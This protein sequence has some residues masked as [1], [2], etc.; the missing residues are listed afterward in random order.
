MRRFFN[1]AGPCLPERHYLVPPES[2]LSEALDLI[3]RQ[4]FFVIHAPRQTGKTTLLHTLAKKLNAEGRYTALVT[5][6]EFLQRV[7]DVGAGLVELVQMIHNAG[8]YSSLAAEE[9]PPE[10]G[11]ISDHPLQALSTY[12][13]RWAEACPKPIVLLIDEIDSLTDDLLISVLRQLRS[14]YT[15]RQVAP[16]PSSVALVGLRDVRDYKAGL[17]DEQE[18]LGTASPFNV[19]ARSLTL[20]NFSAGEIRQ[21]LGQHTEDTGQRFEAQV[22]Q[23]IFEQT[24]G[25]PWLVNALAAECVDTLVKDR[26]QP[27]TSAHVMEAREILIRRRDTHLDSLADK[28]RE[29]RVRRIIEPILAGQVLPPEAMDDDLMYARDLGLVTIS[30]SVRIANPIYQEVIPRSLTFVLQR[31]I[32]NDTAWYVLPDGTLDMDALLAA[33]QEFY[34]EHSE[35]WLGRY[36]Q[37]EAGPHLILMAFLQRVVNGGGTIDREFALGSGR[38]DLVVSFGGR[39][40]PLELKLYRGP[41]TLEQGMTQLSRY[42]DRLGERHGWLV[43]FDQR[44]GRTWEEKLFFKELEGAAGQRITWVGA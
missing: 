2:R 22:P 15:Q 31:T 20:T 6:I 40:Y 36:D 41:K 24:G 44:E 17:R 19:K 10:P 26:S 9:R 35:P 33:F 23:L 12:L 14:G 18:S 39:R 25:Q 8:Q 29:P 32:P 1:V 37:H 7:T 21:L 4:L 28:L 3:E 30:P 34:A 27:I 43:T 13:T 11:T 16:F 38:A 5:N 42:L